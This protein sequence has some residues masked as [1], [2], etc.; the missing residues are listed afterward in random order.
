MYLTN[1][2]YPRFRSAAAGLLT[3]FSILWSHTAGAQQAQAEKIY[4][5]VE[6]M[7]QPSVNI[8]DYLSKNLR[9]PEAAKKAGI[10]GRV[11]AQFVVSK[12]GAVEDVAIQRGI[13]PECDAE[14]LRVLQALPAFTPGRQAGKA[15]N[16]YYTVPVS[17]RLAKENA[18]ATDN[19]RSVETAAGKIFTSVE[20][21]PQPSVDLARYLSENLRYPDAARKAG[22]QGRVI[23]QF[24]VSPT[25]TLSDI[26]IMRGLDPECDAEVLRVLQAMPAFIPGRQNGKAVAVYYTLPVSFRLG[27]GNAAAAPQ[28]SERG[29][30]AV[31][32][33]EDQDLK[34]HPN[35]VSDQVSIYVLAEKAGTAQVYI[36]DMSGRELIHKTFTLKASAT[37]VLLQINVSQLPA[38]TYLLEQ[39]LNGRQQSAR[40]VI[41]R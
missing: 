16:V 2:Y 8:T 15:V 29:A 36:R 32:Q 18:K 40:F 3:A 27:G 35:P 26:A 41:R 30:A 28:A 13:H 10:E 17:F 34:F 23:A 11:V 19:S 7:P 12:N 5:S 24:V 9:Y 39:Q 31:Q 38:G 14:V 22:I 4:S 37:E 1:K 21:M 6:V 25:G 20:D 33:K